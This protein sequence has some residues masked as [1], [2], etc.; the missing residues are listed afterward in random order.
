MDD[1]IF[2]KSIYT[3]YVFKAF[4]NL[5]FFGSVAILFYLDWAC[6]DY[7]RAFILEA[8]FVLFVVLLEIPTG[9][10]ADRFGRKVSLV[11][12][13]VIAGC[14][15]LFFG[16][17]NSYAVFFFG[18]FLCATGM[19]LISGAD[20]A[21]L[22]DILLQYGEGN[23][24]KH[25]FSRSDAF[26][27]AGILLSFPIG[28]LLAGNT[29]ITYPGGLPLTFIL[30]G[31]SFLLAGGVVLLVKEPQR[32]EK[33]SHPLKE[34]VRGFLFIF[35]HS[36]MK[37]Y[38]FNFALI[39]STTFYIYWFYQKI[40]GLA[41]LRVELNGFIG[42]GFNLFGL[43]LLINIPW[44]DKRLG[45]KKLLFISALLPGMLFILLGFTF[46][47]FISLPSIFLI[48]GLKQFR[49]PLLSDLMNHLI[50]SRNRATVLSGVSM[51]E[52]I[53]QFFLYPLI[54]FIADKSLNSAMFILGGV[55]LFFLFISKI[56]ENTT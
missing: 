3:L 49:A 28:S 13:G 45:T 8:A 48:T 36:D 26:G 22:F 14:G 30:S 5:L 42:A 40:T 50:E 2:R 29:V 1:S 19:T 47:P 21:I 32:H 52:R 7:T 41:G 44:F 15:F 43:I 10:I 6:L 18:N 33:I 12:G 38:S 24:A 35:R 39:S 53:I 20:R 55:T 34:G 25:Y 46:S 17:F 54:G 9:V 11:A 37:L 16:I 4:T 31:I 51:L 23:D 27:T 56:P